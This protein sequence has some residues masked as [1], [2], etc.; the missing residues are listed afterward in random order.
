MRWR[1]SEIQIQWVK[2][3]QGQTEIWNETGVQALDRW[4]TCHLVL[5]GPPLATILDTTFLTPPFGV[6]KPL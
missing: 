4:D 6:H 5:T 1:R 2:M 3:N